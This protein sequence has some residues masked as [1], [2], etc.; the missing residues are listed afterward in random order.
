MS[1]VTYLRVM[2]LMYTDT[3]AVH[4]MLQSPLSRDATTSAMNATCTAQQHSESESCLVSTSHVSYTSAM[5]TPQQHS[6]YPSYA[7]TSYT[8]HIP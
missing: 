2:S 6:A 3:A 4:M 7:Y 5:N 1:H 8:Y